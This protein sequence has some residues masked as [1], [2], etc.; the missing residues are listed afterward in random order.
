MINRKLSGGVLKVDE[1]KLVGPFFI[2][3]EKIGKKRSIDKLLLYLWD[4]VLRHSRDSFFNSDINNF[5]DL[6]EKFEVEDVLDLIQRNEDINY[7]TVDNM[8]ELNEITEE[9]EGEYTESEE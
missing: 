6:S 3:P 9:L 7:M 2:K 4:D 1:D 8:A 5:A